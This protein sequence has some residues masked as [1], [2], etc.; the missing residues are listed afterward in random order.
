MSNYINK[1]YLV[2]RAGV[3]PA[4]F[5]VWE[6]YSLLPSPLGIPVQSVSDGIYFM[7]I[8]NNKLW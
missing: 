6:I 3:E 8:L 2:D 7:S 1:K 5:L 4:V